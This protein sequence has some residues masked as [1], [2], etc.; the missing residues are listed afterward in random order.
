MHGP[1]KP[2][3]TGEG[4]NGARG[5]GPGRARCAV[6]WKGVDGRSRRGPGAPGPSA[7]PGAR[8]WWLHGAPGLG[9]WWRP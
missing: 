4:A 2:G 5:G 8:G 7:G 1:A 3:A 9:G 6:A